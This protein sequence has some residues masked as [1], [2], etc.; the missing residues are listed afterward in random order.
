M[1]ENIG[2]VKAKVMNSQRQT[3]HVFQFHIALKEQYNLQKITFTIVKE[4]K[5]IKYCF[6]TLQDS[7]MGAGNI[8]LHFTL[9]LVN[10]L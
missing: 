6:Y 8:L 5:K 3:I 2:R 7:E 10:V 1:S 9:I 4:Q